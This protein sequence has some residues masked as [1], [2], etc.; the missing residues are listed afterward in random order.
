MPL[1]SENR[2]KTYSPP[3]LKKL[4]PEQANLILIGQASYG[5]QG[6]RDLLEVLYPMPETPEEGRGA[7][8]YF[9]EEEPTPIEP[10]AY[11][12]IRRALTVLQSAREDFHRFVRG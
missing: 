6:A 8:A 7:R 12:L 1:E 11:R 3:K 5:D 2:R 9:E 4:T 10:T